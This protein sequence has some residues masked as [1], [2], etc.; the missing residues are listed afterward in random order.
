MHVQSQDSIHTYSGCTNM[1]VE[2]NF[3]LKLKAE[4][5]STGAV[6]GK[7]SCSVSPSEINMLGGMTQVCATLTE[8]NLGSQP[9]GT[10]NVTV[11]NIKIFVQPQS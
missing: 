11:A 5:T 3:N 2:C 6:G 9:G 10:D 4:I 1:V 7:Y 8:A